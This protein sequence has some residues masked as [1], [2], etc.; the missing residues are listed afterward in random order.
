ME[1]VYVCIGLMYNFN[2]FG[3]MNYM[4]GGE[5]SFGLILEIKDM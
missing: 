4:F 2:V 1:V 5:G 3:D